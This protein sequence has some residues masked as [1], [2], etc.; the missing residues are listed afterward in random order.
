MGGAC[1]TYEGFESCIKGLVG[2]PERKTTYRN[3]LLRPRIEKGV[4]TA[5]FYDGRNFKSCIGL[6]GENFDT[7]LKTN[8]NFFC[9]FFLSD[10]DLSL[11]TLSIAPHVILLC[12]TLQPG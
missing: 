5:L 12:G 3:D 1:G 7:Q 9:V 8:F 4:F 2:K 6:A 11:E 10:V